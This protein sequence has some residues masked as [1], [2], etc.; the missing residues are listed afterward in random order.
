MHSAF[1]GLQGSVMVWV[2]RK[3]DEE[4]DGFLLIILVSSPVTVGRA[5]G[6]TVRLDEK[7][8]SRK[9]A[10]FRIKKNSHPTQIIYEDLSVFPFS[11]LSPILTPPYTGQSLVLKSTGINA[12]PSARF[13]IVECKWFHKS[14]E[15]FC[16]RTKIVL[17]EGDKI[18]IG[19][20]PGGRFR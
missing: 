12:T 9:H 1:Q 7:T 19:S 17:K 14:P 16:C 20:G 13:R 2:L 3:E 8:I 6:S 15:R 11:M 5:V 10:Q 18:Q 4:S